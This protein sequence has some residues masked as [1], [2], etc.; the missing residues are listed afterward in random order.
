M[1][2]KLQS[3]RI[4]WIDNA[5]A[6]SILFIVIGHTIADGILHSY[7]FSFHVPIFFF[8]SGVT[9]STKKSPLEFVKD[10]FKRLLIPY[11]IFSL[12]SIFIYIF[13]GNAVL[14]NSDSNREML[15]VKECL[16]GMLWGT[17]N[18]GWMDW[19]RPLWFLPCLF[20]LLV[21]VYFIKKFLMKDSEKMYPL[22]IFLIIS[23]V[24]FFV[25]RFN[26]WTPL[27]PFGILQALNALPF[28]IAGIITKKIL[29][30]KK[31]DLKIHIAIK[32]LLSIAFIAA[33]AYVNTL[34][35]EVV[36][37]AADH[38]GISWIYMLS[39]VLSIIG[40][41]LLSSTFE[42]KFV[43]YVGRNTMPILLMHKFPILFFSFIPFMD[44]DK[45]DFIGLAV[46]VMSLIM[47][48]AV[49]ELIKKICPFIIGE[50]KKSVS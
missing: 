50:K 8:L 17:R 5:R 1:A 49:G 46:A 3:K 10:K 37:F 24:L 41:C 48:V 38:F 43:G 36:S 39:A 19:N 34:N 40:W 15:T 30:S 7:V 23:I 6:F 21:A 27:L 16:L 26:N 2:E 35:S 22:W 29:Y 13:L 31:T 11:W 42:L 33:G 12:I 25:M 20:V 9:F 14:Q 32:L 28:F 18:S 4:A 47:C 44:A 45:N